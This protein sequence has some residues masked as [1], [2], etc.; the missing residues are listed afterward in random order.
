MFERFTQDARELVVEAKQEAR[1]L[2]HS[3]IGH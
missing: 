2:G 1:A 3:W